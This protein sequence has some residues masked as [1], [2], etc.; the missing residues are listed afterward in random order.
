MGELKKNS[1]RVTFLDVARSFAIISITFNHAVGRSF[2]VYYDQYNE[3][4]TIPLYATI[5]KAIFYAFSRIGVPVF[6]MISGALLLPRDYSNGGAS[7]FLKNN[8]LKLFITT[9]VWLALMFWYNQGSAYSVLHTQGAGACLLR[10]VLNQL[11]INPQ[12]FACMWYMEMILCVYLLIPI[13]SVAL[14]KLDHK[15]FLLPLALVA[16]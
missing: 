9:E 12:E 2:N 10:F 11:F 4:L 14:K 5:L 15:Y 7:R 16:F 13:L 6:L 3:Y 1:G 8:W